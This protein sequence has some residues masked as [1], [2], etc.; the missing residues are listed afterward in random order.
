MQTQRQNLNLYVLGLL[1][2]FSLTVSAQNVVLELDDGD[3]P[4]PL[5]SSSQVTID[6]AG[7]LT[8]DVDDDN[9]PGCFGTPDGT[10]LDVTLTVSPS[11]VNQGDTVTAI[12]NVVGFVN[13]VTTCTPSGGTLP[14]RQEFAASPS[15]GSGNYTL[16]NTTTFTVNCSNGSDSQARTVNVNGST[17]GTIPD[18]N[19]SSFGDDCFPSTVAACG[20]D[21]AGR[22]LPFQVREANQPT[23][24]RR[25]YDEVFDPNVWPNSSDAVS[26]LIPDQNYV[27]MPFI[28][29]PNGAA[30]RMTWVDN[31]N[32]GQFV[33]ASLST[34][35]G[36]FST[37]LPDDCITVTSANG[38]IVAEVNPNS[39]ACGLTENGIYY[40]NIRHAGTGGSDACNFSTCELLA[41]PIRLIR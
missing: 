2:L 22:R 37:S 36:D 9:L 27:A 28:A 16:N 19:N 34:C 26:I 17:G 39:S 12:W 30:W 7:N 32:T 41:R 25:F 13:G 3:C 8:V 6:D 11:T 14:W 1:S 40:L 20:A 31:P 21:P 33:T 35:P 18:C 38:S 5:E 29:R 23:V 15:G 24:S 10:P 4:L